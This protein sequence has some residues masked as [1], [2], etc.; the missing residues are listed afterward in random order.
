M[1]LDFKHH[2]INLHCMCEHRSPITD[3]CKLG[4]IHNLYVFVRVISHVCLNI[5]VTSEIQCKTSN[6]Q[7]KTNN[8]YQLQVPGLGQA[9]DVYVF[10]LCEYSTLRLSWDSGVF[11]RRPSVETLKVLSS[12]LY[13]ELVFSN[14]AFM[15]DAQ[16]Y[17]KHVLYF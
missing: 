8:I 3:F 13:P 2:S 12:G 11:K 1:K 17:L 6:I 9:H 4:W 15:R 5:A 7:H 14:R 10:N 16:N